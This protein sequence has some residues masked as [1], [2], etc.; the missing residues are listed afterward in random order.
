VIACPGDNGANG[1]RVPSAGVRIP[2]FV[3]CPTSLSLEQDAARA[4]V[5]QKL[6]GMGLEA[7]AV[8]RS[9]YPTELPLREVLVLARHC[10]GGVILGFEQYRSLEGIDKPRTEQELKQ[11]FRRFPTPW[12]HIEAGI[13]FGQSLPLLIFRE[14]GILGGIFDPGVTDVFVHD[15]PDPSNDDTEEALDA[16]FLKWQA[17]VRHRYYKL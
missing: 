11:N 6:A 17:E 2:V 7:R 16:V 4:V 8:G 14:P 10:S 15:M 5:L 1:W 13:L 12:N 9:D 3:S